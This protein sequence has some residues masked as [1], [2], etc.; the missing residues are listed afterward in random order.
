MEGMI[1]ED[2]VRLALLQMKRDPEF[3]SYVDQCIQL[4][5]RQKVIRVGTQLESIL[6]CAP[7]GGLPLATI[8]RESFQSQTTQP[9]WL[10][11]RQLA[12]G[13]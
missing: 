2:S 11:A 8:W 4:L 6:G 9:Q 5:Q 13:F 3:S 1:V 12:R 7:T 10:R